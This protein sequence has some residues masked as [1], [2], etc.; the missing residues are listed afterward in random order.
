ML[1]IIIFNA[2]GGKF[3]TKTDSDI[4]WTLIEETLVC[5]FISIQVVSQ[6]FGWRSISNVTGTRKV[7]D[8]GSR[9]RM[10]YAVLLC[11]NTRNGK[12]IPWLA[13]ENIFGLRNLHWRLITRV[14][15]H[16][17]TFLDYNENRSIKEIKR[18]AWKKT[19][20]VAG[21]IGFKWDNSHMDFLSKMF[22]FYQRCSRFSWNIFS[23]LFYQRKFLPKPLTTTPLVVNTKDKNPVA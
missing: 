9:W 11:K 16:I 8:N 22:C 2:L 4:R 10:I 14:Y 20:R 21:Q 12:E 17:S 18:M 6:V 23:L 15:L 5:R 19:N 13:Y 3:L 1:L 7:F